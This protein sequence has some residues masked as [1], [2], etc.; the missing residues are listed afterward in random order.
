MVRD[1]GVEF[2]PDIFYMGVYGP[3]E[4]FELIAVSHFCNLRAAQHF[5]RVTGQHFH[6]FILCGGEGHRCSFQ[7]H[8]A[9]FKIDAQFACDNFRAFSSPFFFRPDPAHDGLYPSSHL[10]RAER[11]CDIVIGAYLEPYKLICL[12]TECR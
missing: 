5:S 6:D 2:L 9:A 12:I 10:S 7:A 3:V 11:L 4:S 1:Q 8:A